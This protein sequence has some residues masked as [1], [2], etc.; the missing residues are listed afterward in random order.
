[1]STRAP[2]KPLATNSRRA[3]RRMRSRVRTGSRL[4]VTI[5]IPGPCSKYP[6]GYLTCQAGGG[7]SRRRATGRRGG[8]PFVVPAGGGAGGAGGRRGGSRGVGGGGPAVHGAPEVLF[9]LG[10]GGR[11]WRAQRRPRLRGGR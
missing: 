10:G 9:R 2:A 5:W 1:A 3:A 4:E 7:E 6:C 11:R 8:R